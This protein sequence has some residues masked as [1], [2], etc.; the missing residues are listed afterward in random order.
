M[1]VRSL[2]LVALLAITGAACDQVLDEGSL[3]ETLTRQVEDEI[4]EDN[5]TVDCPS[6]VKVEA[7]NVFTCDVTGDG[8]VA[9]LEVTQRDDGGHVEWRFVDAAA[10]AAAGAGAEG[11]AG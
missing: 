8:A 9:T 10:D 3:E 2:F 11:D 1:R 6:D 5:L 7:G 4:G